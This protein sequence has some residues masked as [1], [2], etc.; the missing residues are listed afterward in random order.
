[1]TGNLLLVVE[2]LTI[3]TFLLYTF[4]YS[5]NFSVIDMYYNLKTNNKLV[6]SKSL[7]YSLSRSDDLPDNVCFSQEIATTFRFLCCHRL[8][9]NRFWQHISGGGKFSVKHT[10]Q[11]L[12]RVEIQKSY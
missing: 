1:M 4:P 5:Q 6:A 12:R 11:V 9:D 7:K 10:K 3:Y 2:L 8:H